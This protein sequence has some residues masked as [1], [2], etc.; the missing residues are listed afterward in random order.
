MKK[1][2]GLTNNTYLV[3]HDVYKV[4]KPINDIYLDKNNEVNVL[5]AFMHSD[6]DLMIKPKSFYFENEQL[7]SKFEF[8]PNFKSIAEQT[9]TSEI[10]CA[11]AQAIKTFH[12][13]PVQTVA[14]K[15]FNY[16]Q[17]IET[18]VR[19]IK[20]PL[21]D[22][23]NAIKK[24]SLYYKLWK[25]LPQVL[26]HNDL[27]PGNILINELTGKLVLIDYDYIMMNNH[28]FDIASF[29]TETCNDN[30][31]LIEVFLAECLKIGLL[32]ES[33]LPI[34]NACIAYQDVLWTLWA[35]YM[36]EVTNRSL[37][38]EIAIDKYNRIQQRKKF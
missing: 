29:I 11:V 7:H 5:L 1:L 34:L 10:V 24:I 27:V 14:I 4:S 21:F 36:Y 31:K 15:I 20:T 2:D 28:F 37:F 33:D 6:Q 32:V 12:N 25:T 17:M 30:D 13:L 22:L 18:F 35:N 16:Q 9:L 23:T 3:D 26:S 38:L 8:L 19:E